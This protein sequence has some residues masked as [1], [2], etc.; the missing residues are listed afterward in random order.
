MTTPHP[1]VA[2]LA[3]AVVAAAPAPRAPQPA[4]P[5]DIARLYT[6]TWAEIARHPQK[7][8][9]GCIAS[10]THYTAKGDDRIEVEDFCHDKTIDGKLKTIGGPGTITDPGTNA[11]L[12]V[13]YRF[14]GFVPVAR[15]YWI[16]DHA[17]DYSW[18]ISADPAFDQLWIYT[19]ATHPDPALLRTLVGKAKAMGYDPAQLEFP[20]QP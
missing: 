7:L 5:V 2:L 19:R 14:L 15:E 9:D 1:I 4:K 8:T 6:G 13:R 20:A 12:H 11:K 18:F 17:D 10:G 16:L 3:L